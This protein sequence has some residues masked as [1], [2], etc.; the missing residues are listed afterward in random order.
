MN[1]DNDNLLTVY[2][3]EYQK[4][5]D[6]QI[7]RIGFRDNMIY[8]NL[9]AV[10]TVGAF[11][12]T[13]LGN[14]QALF[15]IPW[16]C[17]IL[18]WTYLV[19]D[20]KISSIGKYIRIK[21]DDR[22]QNELNNTKKSILLGWEVAH[23]DDKYRLE[24][25]YFQLFVDFLTFCVSGLAAIVIFWLSKPTYSSTWLW[26]SIIES[27]FLFLLGIQMVKYADLKSGK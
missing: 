18:G 8:T 11:A 6:E 10:G 13:S 3:Q 2:L 16:I 7:Q 27:L 26:I 9:I 23:R 19:N 17:F 1:D 12:V 24:R 4:L 15:I 21:L 20:E 14:I 5:K 22:I 25:K